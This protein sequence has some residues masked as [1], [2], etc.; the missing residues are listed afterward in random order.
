MQFVPG[1]FSDAVEFF[2]RHRGR[3]T[4]SMDQ[5]IA[6]LR[7]WSIWRIDDPDPIAVFLVKDGYG[8]V[9][10]YGNAMVGLRRIRKAMRYLDIDKTTVGEDFSGG[11]ALAKRL[12]FHIDHIEGKVTHYA[13]H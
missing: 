3:V 6:I 2:A 4:C 7:E 1:H 9:A 5:L 10:G 8:H 13:L 12:G 11:H